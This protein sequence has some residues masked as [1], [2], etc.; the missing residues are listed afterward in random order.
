VALREPPI[1][2][3]EEA[4][5]LSESL[6]LSLERRLGGCQRASH[7]HYRGSWVAVREPPIVVREEVRWLSE[8]LPF[9]LER[10]L[11][12]CQRASHCH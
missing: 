7:C 2:I 8:S 3:R 6:P 11:G 4:G 9:S 12:G 1:V 10:K 5:W